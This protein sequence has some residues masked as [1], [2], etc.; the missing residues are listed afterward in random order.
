MLECS[1]TL[2]HLSRRVHAVNQPA[3]PSHL[4][5]DVGDTHTH[6]HTYEFRL[7]S[8]V[9]LDINVEHGTSA[10]AGESESERDGGDVRGKSSGE[11]K[12]EE[13]M[14]GWAGGEKHSENSGLLQRVT[15]AER[16]S[17]TPS[18]S[19]EEFRA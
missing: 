5:I 13:E 8:R 4:R 18:S 2:A 6:T 3:F 7:L 16:Q 19:T 14:E 17:N 10:S 12:E 11:E 9:L 15:A 1:P